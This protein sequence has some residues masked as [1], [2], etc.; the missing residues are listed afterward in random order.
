MSCTIISLPNHV[1]CRPNMK[2]MNDA[3]RFTKTKLIQ[4]APYANLGLRENLPRFQAIALQNTCS[5]DGIATVSCGAK[6]ISGMNWCTFDMGI[7]KQRMCIPRSKIL[8]Q[9][10]GWL[11]A[12]VEDEMR[13]GVAT[14]LG[15]SRLELDW[16]PYSGCR[17]TSQFPE[18]RLRHLACLGMLHCCGKGRQARVEVALLWAPTRPSNVVKVSVLY[19]LRYSVNYVGVVVDKENWCQCPNGHITT[20]ELVFTEC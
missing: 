12:G 9:L 7:S 15:R 2:Y 11:G 14:C 3:A 6:H 17:R 4:I 10:C 5:Y 19:K 18:W 20:K 16:S 8:I 1:T 13:R